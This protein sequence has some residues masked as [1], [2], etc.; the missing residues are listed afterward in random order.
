[1]NIELITAICAAEIDKIDPL[2]ELQKVLT[3][4][5]NNKAEDFETV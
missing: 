4:L 3:K 1:M 2:N 5:K